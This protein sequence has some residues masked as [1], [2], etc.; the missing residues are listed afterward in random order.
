LN[1]SKNK[2][3]TTLVKRRALASSAVALKNQYDLLENNTQTDL[4]ENNL[5]SNNIQDEKDK[6]SV[7]ADS[8]LDSNI[9]YNDKTDNMSFFNTKKDTDIPSDY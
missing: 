4:E 1:N 5:S 2:S 9:S 6:D 3:A 7:M 8:K